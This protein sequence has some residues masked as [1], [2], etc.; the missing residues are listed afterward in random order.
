M[1]AMDYSFEK[2]PSVQVTFQKL[3]SAFKDFENLFSGHGKEYFAIKRRKGFYIQADE[4]RYP[5]HFTILREFSEPPKIQVLWDSAW[6][7]EKVDLHR[8]GLQPWQLAIKVHGLLIFGNELK[9]ELTILIRSGN[10]GE[11]TRLRVAPM[12]E[13]DKYCRIMD[14]VRDSNKKPNDLR[15][16][17]R[18]LPRR[19]LGL[20]DEDDAAGETESKKEEDT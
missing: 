18:V 16:N 14:Y 3:K 6:E 17:K 8:I 7:E 5:H 9:E 11:G 2:D 19:F 20:E 13:G 1:T 10:G 12:E 4:G 15:K